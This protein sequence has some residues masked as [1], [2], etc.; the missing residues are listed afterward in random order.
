LCPHDSGGSHWSGLL[1]SAEALCKNV[2]EHNMQIRKAS[3]WHGAKNL[4]DQREY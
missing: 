3:S 4:E 1:R 2:S